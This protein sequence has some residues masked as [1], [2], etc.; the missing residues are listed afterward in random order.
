[1]KKGIRLGITFGISGLVA[2]LVILCLILGKNEMTK[3]DVSAVTVLSTGFSFEE[4]KN[5]T[6]PYGFKEKKG[7]AVVFSTIL[8]ENLSDDAGVMFQTLYSKCEVYVDG[9][10]TASYAE[11][12]PY[13]FGRM[14]G[15]IRLIA[16]LDSSMSGKKV[17]FVITPYYTSQADFAPVLTG[18]ISALETYVFIKNFAR[19]II[20][21]F[22]FAIMLMSVGLTLYQMQDRELFNAPLLADF[23]FFVFL[24]QLWIWCSSDLP[25]YITNSNAVTS[26]LSFMCI[27]MMAIPY[28]GFC[29]YVLPE[30]RRYLETLQ[31][32]GWGVPLINVIGYVFNLFDPLEILPLS[33]LYIIVA[34]ISSFVC[35][36]KNFNKGREARML[37]AAV[38]S[39]I[40]SAL[41]AIVFYLIA[42]AQ[43]YAP[44]VVGFGI[45]VF[46]VIMFMLILFRQVNYIKDR[47]Y[48]ETYKELAYKDILTGLGNRASFDRYFADLKEKYVAG[49]QITLFMFDVNYLKM[50]NDTEGHAAGDEIIVAMA[51]TLKKT[52]AG[53]GDCFRLG[54]DEFAAIV[55]GVKKTPERYVKELEDNIDAF[56]NGKKNNLSASYGYSQKIWDRSNSFRQDIYRLADQAMYADKQRKHNL[57]NN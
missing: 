23:S 39:V 3:F 54:G 36:L 49:T 14:S 35:V 11:K 17:E 24:I 27:S 4:E 37:F 9:V 20:I 56:N 33:H 16:P 25:Q 19:L 6:L 47:K 29:K 48:L 26:F 1:M 44:T 21:I 5:I 38:I 2:G 57:Q 34:A 15:N 45:T 43:E 28:L 51:E 22:L 7:E 8:P 32:I 40:A 42:P 52:F 10:K 18:C 50:V 55:P 30:W 13:S 31:Y 41:A 46:V 53:M 12:M